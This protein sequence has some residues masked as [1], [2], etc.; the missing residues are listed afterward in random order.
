M[1][2][3]SPEQLPGLSSERSDPGSQRARSVS[4]LGK[5]LHHNRDSEVPGE[6]GLSCPGSSTPGRSL[7]LS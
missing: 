6:T 7:P 5:E 3:H 4:C 1:R 2:Q